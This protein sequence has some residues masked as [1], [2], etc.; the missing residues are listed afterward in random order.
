[1]YIKINAFL[2]KIQQSYN[3]SDNKFDLWQKS[4]IFW[5]LC[6]VIQAWGLCPLCRFHLIYL[7]TSLQN[8]SVVAK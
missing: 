3:S 6:R 5:V 8:T 7:Y 1:M 2:D 4:T